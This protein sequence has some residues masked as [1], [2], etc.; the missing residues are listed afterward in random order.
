MSGRDD[1]G[2]AAAAYVL[3][4]LES[5]EADR[6]RRHLDECA[7]CRDEV[8]SLQVVADAL[9]LAAPPVALPRG[10][11]RRIVKGARRDRRTERWST[12]A[13][14]RPRLRPAVAIAAVVAVGAGAFAAV[15]L[16]SGG[17]TRIVPAHVLASAGSAYVRVHGGRAV[18]VVNH[19]PP[20]A[21]DQIYEV[22]LKRAG[23]AP[24]PTSALF[25]VDA[26]G[27]RQVAVPADLSDVRQ[28]LVTPER[29]GGSVVPTH[30]PVIEAT[31]T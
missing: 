11:R 3:G 22:W 16:P 19:L 17:G 18:L 20:P 28:L 7:I 9:P 27:A 24:Q 25:D 13:R 31:L 26:A 2:A 8:G 14:A 1:C 12:I 10:L 30:A 21:P 23:E 6:F 5:D 4:A 29:L 15:E